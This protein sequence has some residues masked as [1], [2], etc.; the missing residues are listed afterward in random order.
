MIL[1]LHPFAHHCKQ[2]PTSAGT[3]AP[4]NVGSYCVRLDVGS[5]MN[6]IARWVRPT[7]GI[8]SCQQPIRWS[9]HLLF[10]PLESTLSRVD[11]QIERLLEAPIEERANENREMTV[12]CLASNSRHQVHSSDSSG[13]INKSTRERVN[14]N[15]VPRFHSVTGNHIS[16]G[17]VR[18]GYEIRLTQE[19]N[20]DGG[21][22]WWALGAV[23]SAFG[24]RRSPSTGADFQH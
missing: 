22:I 12:V 6:K 8:R 17:R 1:V 3:T 24:V 9:L 13:S 20:E 4:K 18:S 5:E 10:K 16:S 21:S 14:S 2:Q 11:L 7:D 15:L 23:H 19:I